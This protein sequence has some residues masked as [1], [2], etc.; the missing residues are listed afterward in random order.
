MK[1]QDQ[2]LPQH[3][4]QDDSR[5]SSTISLISEPTSSYS[6]DYEEVLRAIHS[7]SDEKQSS[8]TFDLEDDT[9]VFKTSSKVVVP[10]AY[11]IETMVWVRSSALEEVRNLLKE[12]G[13]PD[14]LAGEVLPALSTTFLGALVSLLISQ[15]T[16]PELNVHASIYC[17]LV[18]GT[19]GCG[20]AWITRRRYQAKNNDELAKRA[21]SCLPNP[22]ECEVTPGEHR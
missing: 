3:G 2:S 19:V 20:V 6:L 15:L 18:A 4:D 10:R 13:K 22:D 8:F 16:T 14:G 7:A 9:A 21:L 1:P 12:L 5:P 17:V 11:Q